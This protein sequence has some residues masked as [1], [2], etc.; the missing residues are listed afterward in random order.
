MIFYNSRE[1]SN[2]LNVNIAKWKRWVREFLPPDPLGG[3][4]SGYARQFNLKEAFRVFL[5]GYL[6]SALKFTIPEARQILKDLDS[7]LKTEGFYALQPQ[8]NAKAINGSHAL[9]IY[10]FGGVD[11]EFAFLI[12]RI[13][14]SEIIEQVKSHV[15]HYDQEVMSTQEDPLS[16]GVIAGGRILFIGTLYVK[17]FLKQVLQDTK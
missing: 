1:L 7:W 9:R 14:G 6:V 3:L 4:Q 8:N 17:H 15:D 13:K 10:I 12:Q 11:Q 2:K 16:G 5:G